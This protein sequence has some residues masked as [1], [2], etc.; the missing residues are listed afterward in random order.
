MH[1]RQKTIDEK[2]G[3]SLVAPY[4]QSTNHH[5]RFGKCYGIAT[6]WGIKKLDP[7]TKTIFSLKETL[8]LMPVKFHNNK[9]TSSINRFAPISARVNTHQYSQFA[10][11]R[12][13]TNRDQDR[14]LRSV[15]VRCAGQFYILPYHFD[16]FLDAALQ[17]PD[18][19]VSLLTLHSALVS[20]ALAC[21]RTERV[22]NNKISIVEFFDPNTGE[23]TSKS[24]DG[25]KNWFSEYINK[26]YGILFTSG[27]FEIMRLKNP[28]KKLSI[29]DRAIS[30]L[31]STKVTTAV[32]LI[33]IA[34]GGIIHALVGIAETIFSK[35]KPLTYVNKQMNGRCFDD[36]LSTAK[37]IEKL[38]L[39][40][41]KINGLNYNC[42]NGLHSYQQRMKV[43]DD[44]VVKDDMYTPPDHAA[45]VRTLNMFA[46]R[47]SSSTSACTTRHHKKMHGRKK[48]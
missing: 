38:G 37:V 14:D 42:N 20:H 6:E 11:Y 39:Y 2:Y 46:N 43:A 23:F 1:N 47:Q 31:N 22:T 34:R 29:T 16:K 18:D 44:R 15:D 36:N 27:S 13:I 48:H 19:T 26:T 21:K 30:L 32:T 24:I 25:F 33:N 41:I 17:Q 8:P 28:D 7:D 35:R 40:K 4:A 12:L 3:V 10:P 5:V 9:I 45:R